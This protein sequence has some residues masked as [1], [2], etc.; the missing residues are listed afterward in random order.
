MPWTFVHVTERFAGHSAWLSA[1]FRDAAVV[2]RATHEC[3]IAAAATVAF[4]T[5]VNEAMHQQA[6]VMSM[7]TKKKLCVLSAPVEGLSL[8]CTAGFGPE[9]AK[10]NDRY[11]LL[12]QQQQKML[13][14]SLAGPWHCC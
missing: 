5:A 1:M 8:Q 14:L 11:L 10:N 6:F 3:I 13:S 4:A 12:Q 9:T 2:S 7:A